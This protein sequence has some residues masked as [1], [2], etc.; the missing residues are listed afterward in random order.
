MVNLYAKSGCLFLDN[1]AGAPNE[2]S[3]CFHRKQSFNQSIFQR[4]EGL[5]SA[6][7]GS[8][9]HKET[10]TRKRI[11]ILGHLGFAI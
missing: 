5:Q 6:R 9:R 3:V 2:P 10:V 8:F 7:S 11:G 1:L 4:I